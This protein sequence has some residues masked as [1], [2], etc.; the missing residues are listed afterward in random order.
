[1]SRKIKEE[2][3]EKLA[4]PSKDAR[5]YTRWWWYGCNV[6][7]E[8]I[9]KELDEMVR[10]NIGG[11]ELQIMYALEAD[12]YVL[13]ADGSG[14][15]ASEREGEHVSGINR[16][17]RRNHFYLSPEYL[18]LVAFAAEEANKRGMKFDMTLVPPGPMAVL[19]CRRN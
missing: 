1:M 17:E 9:K 14:A 15:A 12:D 6:E 5:G 4:A 8:E 2:V 10:A 11:V 19:L 7:K 3:R 16:G 13:E 18:E